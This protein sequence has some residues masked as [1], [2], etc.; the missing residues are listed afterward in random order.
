MNKN[1]PMRSE[2]IKR[3]IISGPVFILVA[4]ER[5]H[6]YTSQLPVFATAFIAK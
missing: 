1:H 4:S 6:S 2:I 3:I 5:F